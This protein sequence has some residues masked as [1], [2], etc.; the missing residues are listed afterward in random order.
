M[1]RFATASGP[2]QF[3]QYGARADAPVL[4]MHDVGW[5][6][7]HW[8]PSLVDGL[9]DAGFRVITHDSRDTGLSFGL[10]ADSVELADVI[11]N[12]G[13]M[14]GVKPAYTLSDMAGDACRLLDHLG[15]SGAHLVGF[16]LGAMVAQRLAIHHPERVFT[17][18]S[19]AAGPGAL[20]LPG[21]D[22]DLLPALAGRSRSH[23]EVVGRGIAWARKLGGP[24]HDSA[25][26]GLG[27]FVRAA[28]ARAY[29]PDGAVRQW[30]AGATEP[31]R[32]ALLR[33]LRMPALVIHGDADP[34]VPVTEAQ[35]TAA[36]VPGARLE[37]IEDMGHD[38]PEPAMP[39]LV[40][41]IA[42]LL[43]TT[44]VPR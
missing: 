38:L 34:L 20:P 8:P 11:A 5:Q 23:K 27:R 26:V 17:W 40:D 7:L 24:H 41:H 36:A 15:Q 3:E 13:G 18:T 30:I 2:M 43:R 1:P 19:I 31:D 4:L 32:T 9:V 28:H 44:T 21:P 35:R 10:T 39:T 22:A 16:S 37:I 25:T 12:G 42:A 29:R 33:K 6:L 14:A